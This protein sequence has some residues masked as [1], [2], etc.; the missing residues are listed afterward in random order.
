MATAGFMNYESYPMIEYDDK[1]LKA[2]L[3]AAIKA[4]K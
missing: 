4:A 3:D 2:A 1:S